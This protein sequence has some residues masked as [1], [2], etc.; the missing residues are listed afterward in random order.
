MASVAGCGIRR[1][2]APPDAV[3]FRPLLNFIVA[4]AP[5]SCANASTAQVRDLPII[6]RAAGTTVC[7]LCSAAGDGLF[8]PQSGPASCRG[9]MYVLG[10]FVLPAAQTKPDFAPLWSLASVVRH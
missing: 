6:Q 9:R 7:S 2:L 4:T 10:L 8:A 1:P 3:I 5:V